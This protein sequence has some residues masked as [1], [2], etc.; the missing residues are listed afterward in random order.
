MFSFKKIHLKM[1]SAIFRPFC[2][3]LNMSSDCYPILGWVFISSKYYL[4]V[5]LFFYLPNLQNYLTWA[6]YKDIH[7][8]PLTSGLG[9]NHVLY[10]YNYSWYNFH[11]ILS[12]V[13]L[14]S[15]ELVMHFILLLNLF[16]F[17]HYHNYP[18][19]VT[20]CFWGTCFLH[21]GFKV[22]HLLFC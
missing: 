22:Y 6:T 14:G 9:L 5:W 4:K 18:K 8:R 7:L 19:L 13:G 17:S 12:F 10:F 11:L 2:F 3:S 21:I 1:L 15:S 20:C 16:V